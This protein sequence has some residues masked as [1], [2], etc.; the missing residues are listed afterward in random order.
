MLAMADPLS[1]TVLDEVGFAT[2][3]AVEPAM[4]SERDIERAMTAT[5]GL[6]AR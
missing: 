3:K 6:E 4:K 1:L 5:S 2:G